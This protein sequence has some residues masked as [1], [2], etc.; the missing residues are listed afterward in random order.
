M[1][2]GL[3]NIGNTCSINS[4]LQC[5][6]HCKAIRRFLSSSRIE[7]KHTGSYSI[8]NEL[9]ALVSDL[10]KEGDIIVP[11]RFITSLYE[12]CGSI[13]QH[14]EQHDICEVCTLLC[15][16]VAEECFLPSAL[17][18]YELSHDDIA[19]WN[20]VSKP[21]TRIMLKAAE[22]VQRLNSRNACGWLDMIQG[23]IVI[24]IECTTCGELY[25]NFEPFI[26]LSIQV[27]HDAKTL[28]D[29]LSAFFREEKVDD[30]TCDKCKGRHA[31][32]ITRL[33]K[34]PRVLCIHL[35]RFNGMSKNGSHIDIPE[36]F[37]LEPSSVIGPQYLAQKKNIHY[38]LSSV[39]LH[40]GSIWGGHYTAICRD[41]NNTW[42]HCDDSSCQQVPHP[43]VRE[44]YMMIY[45][46][47]TN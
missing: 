37:Q 2:R 8:T 34:M 1:A 22:T 47:P 11:Q 25:H 19:Y 15:D 24:Q 3:A 40:H 31:I 6:V 5:L 16:K 46:L 38:R 4:L 7:V 13:L 12:K 32:R 29:C 30:W 27:P 41:I 10:W 44:S 43:N 39:A 42:I 18:K 20:N 9:A 33:W 14:G 17:K 21:Y 45:E 36:E 28:Y 23:V 35:K 26:V